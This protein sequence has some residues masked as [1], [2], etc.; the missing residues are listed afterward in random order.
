MDKGRRWR[1]ALG[2]L[3]LAMSL[4]VLAIAPVA[5]NGGPGGG[6]AVGGPMAAG[7][8]ILK[9]I[10]A[11]DLPDVA[12]QYQLDPA[13]L[14]R[15]PIAPLYLMRVLDGTSPDIKATVMSTDPR[16]AYA[17]ANV[18]GSTAEDESASP[19]A[20][21]DGPGPYLG[22]WASGTIRLPLAFKVTRGAGVIVAV[23]DTG[24]DAS[25][26]AL[27]GHLISGY[28]FVDNDANP[29]E[30]GQPV[31]NHGYG[32]G[33]FVAGLVA[34]A[35]PEAAIMPVRM[36]DPD[37]V[38]DVWRLS[39]AMVWAASNG[40]T[41]I[42]LSLSTHTHTHVTNDLITT[43]ALNGR[44]VVVVSAAGNY[45]SNLPQFPAAEGG[46]RVLSVGASS[47]Q[48]TLAPFSDYGSWVRLAAPGMSLYSTIPGGQFA[49]WN[50]TS[51]STGLASGTAALV[52]AAN[53]T[54]SA[55]DVIS[56]LANTSTRISGVVPLLLN[57]GAALGQ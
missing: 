47:P 34:L 27:A 57:A 18:V 54:L 5:A 35:A 10:N 49:S 56:R 26:P 40:A 13:P 15:L 24:V 44:G 39:K 33:T 22:Q 1:H 28:D 16:V 4:W 8:V 20:S 14:D 36:L 19:W 2:A 42:N 30:I 45:A 23:L 55:Q 11:A 46:S 48:D 41:V 29:S 21:G 25:H 9:L 50:G 12:A 17:E 3:T 43:L 53:P 38:G 51:M 31:V 52:R 37:G 7:Q 32:H 6:Y